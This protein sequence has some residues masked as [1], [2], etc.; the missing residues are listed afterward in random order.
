LVERAAESH[1]LEPSNLFCHISSA[2]VFSSADIRVFLYRS[3]TCGSAIDGRF[4]LLSHLNS[5]VERKK[6]SKSFADAESWMK[7]SEGIEILQNRRYLLIIA[8]YKK[9]VENY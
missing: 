9:V 4:D 6:I 5:K 2:T 1:P 8:D 7:R 3:S